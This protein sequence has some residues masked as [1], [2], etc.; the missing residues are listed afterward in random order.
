MSKLEIAC[1]NV[2]S[3]LIAQEVGADRIEFCKN[4]QL[5]GITPDLEDVLTLQSQ[6]NIDLF[7]MIR[8]RG[9]DFNYTLT[10]ISQMEKDILTFKKLGVHGFVFGVL[11]NNHEVDVLINRS[12]VELAHP[13]PCTFHRAFDELENG[14]AAL[15]KIIACGFK[16]LLTSGCKTKAV[17][18][19][20][21]LQ[22]LIKQANHRIEIMPGGGIRS[23]NIKYLHE[24]LAT[25]FYHTAA[26]TSNNEIV[27]INEIKTIKNV[28]TVFQ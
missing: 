27:D 14:S 21:N 2:E 17:D 6:I 10:E 20:K 7:V 22:N 18:G 12:L 11:D 9:S 24:T 1:F 3:A 13:F 26:I 8:P 15:E 23:N 25:N 4:Y 28:F 5:G 16:T 19:I